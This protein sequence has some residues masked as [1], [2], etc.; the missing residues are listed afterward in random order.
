MFSTVVGHV[1][2]PVCLKELA[3]VEA[4]AR[5]T[6]AADQV[7]LQATNIPADPRDSRQLDSSYGARVVI[8]EFIVVLFMV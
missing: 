5:C 8:V 6:A 4:A 1:D 2:V 7:F 3:A